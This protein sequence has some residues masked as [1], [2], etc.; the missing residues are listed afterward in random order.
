MKFLTLSTALSALFNAAY[1]QQT[2]SNTVRHF[3]NRDI[4]KEIKSVNTSWIPFEA[5]K[6]PFRNRTDE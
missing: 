6:N 5:D 1:G 3:V 2:F 4:V